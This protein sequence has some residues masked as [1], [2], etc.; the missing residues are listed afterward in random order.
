MAAD[1]HTQL[2]LALLALPPSSLAAT[3]AHPPVLDSLC[4]L[5]AHAEPVEGNA[6]TRS[7]LHAV[8]ARAAPVKGALA[9]LRL[10]AAYLAAFLPTNHQLA[11]GVVSDALASNVR[12]AD[13]VRTDAVQALSLALA[14]I[15]QSDSDGAHR[16]AQTLLAL[17]R[18]AVQCFSPISTA[19]AAAAQELLSVVLPTYARLASASASGPSSSTAQDELRLS[20]LETVHALLTTVSSAIASSSSS[21]STP[22]NALH[23]LLTLLVPR[24]PH[25]PTPL[26]ADLQTHFS[27]AQT[28][29]D[30]V[31]GSVGPT[32]RQVK[33]LVGALRRAPGDDDGG[34]AA[35]GEWLERLRRAKQVGGAA[36]PQVGLG[37]DKRE[38][39]T[40]AGRADARGGS[41]GAE[42]EA[43]LASAVSHL[44]DLF[45]H[46]APPFL[47]AALVHP[48]F[49]SPSLEAATE[50][51]VASLLDDA[52]LPAELAALKEGRAAPTTAPAPPAPA[53]APAPTLSPAP[54][55][56]RA[57]VYDSDLLFSRGTLLVGGSARKKHESAA[58]AAPLAAARSSALALD[59]QLKASI[60]AMAE[61]PSSDEE[62]DEEEGEG[63]AFLEGDED[64][65]PRVRV[66][67]GE[68]KDADDA[69]ASDEDDRIPDGPQGGSTTASSSSA[70]APAPAPAARGYGPAVQLV[71]ESAY[72]RDPGLFAR[73]GETRRGKGRRTLREQTG[74]GDEQIEGWRSMLERDPKKLQK[75]Q[76]KHQDLAATSN[77]PRESPAPSNVPAQQKQQQQQQHGQGQG[78]GHGG[79]R[80]GRGGSSRGGGSASRGRG[81]GGRRE[82]DRAKRGRDKK[83]A[84]MGAGP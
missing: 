58:S 33:D 9:S 73:D 4:A 68:P 8:V 29:S 69:E 23:S 1:S 42:R 25:P 16:A 44:V 82:H 32:A 70:P 2:L 59:E 76:D 71:L 78:Q 41:G 14:D 77:R 12:L 17:V 18:G 51:L 43:E 26:A 64:G 67:D 55:P 3:L 79:Q 39:T 74:L 63:E 54:A 62:D 47:R 19:G 83:L 56:T 35:A 48:A 65:G 10:V 20:L 46:L 36:D 81:D 60:L 5:L 40:L 6:H 21:A 80:G 50:K 57:N 13:H 53:P 38:E 28:L 15:E 49:A 27:L 37:A 34:D 84:R 45:P 52:P 24:A 72:L 7:L 61:R 30:A 11:L 22:L 66:G 75:M 31:Q